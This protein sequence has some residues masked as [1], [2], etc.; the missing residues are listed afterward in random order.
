MKPRLLLIQPI[1]DPPGGG[2]A[3]SAWMLE[4]LKDEF[5]IT[6]LTCGPCDLEAINR[7]YGT[8]LRVS[9]FAVKSPHALIRFL[10]RLDRDENSIQSANYLLRV[11][12]KIG[13]EFDLILSANNEVDFGRPGIQYIH[14]PYLAPHYSR[15]L[16]SRGETAWQTLRGLFRKEIA[17]WMVISDFSFERMKNNLSLVNSNWTGRRLKE[18]YG[19]DSHTLY[20]PVPG[21][22]PQ[23][24]WKERENGFVCIG[25]IHPDK[26]FGWIIETLAQ[27]RRTTPDL[28]L[29]I[30]GTRGSKIKED[31]CF[32]RLSPL[33]KANASWIQ[34]HENL[35]LSELANL[36]AHQR[37]GIHAQVEEHFGIAVA[38]MVRGGCIT[39]VHNSGGQVEIVGNDPRL[40]FDSDEHAIERINAVL[41][42][43]QRQ[44]DLIRFI[45]DRKDLFST[46]RFMNEMRRVVRG[47]RAG[48][49]ATW[50]GAS[51]TKV[52]ESAA[53]PWR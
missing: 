23:V 43:R 36:V 16:H 19:I 20:P 22:F 15:Y 12:K 27:V 37:Y 28:Q 44:A 18:F 31:L 51:A 24:P 17:P 50:R 4:A 39:F 49:N 47:F 34:L 8:S 48:P 7:F 33:L 3:V 13:P 25:R 30:V 53:G 9:D 38:E 52:E 5:A 42:D 29:H 46:E 21:V 14:Y 11:C 35:S 10:F 41:S 6:V 1:L 32:R 40:L 26:R 45:D 2:N